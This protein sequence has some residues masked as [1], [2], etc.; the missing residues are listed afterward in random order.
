MIN[1][2]FDAIQAVEIIVPGVSGGN[3]Q[4]LFQFPQLSYLA[5]NSAEIVGIEILTINTITKS[6]ISGT[7]LV[8][9]ANLQTSFLTL[10]G[11]IKG[12]I[13]G[14]EVIQRVALNR[15]NV[16]Q[17]ATPDPFVREVMPLNKMQ[18]DWTK[19]NVYMQTA[20][21]NTGNV[22]FVFNVYFNYVKTIQQY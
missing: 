19:S 9:A 10:Y 11:G 17:N 7:A 3:T 12:V 16:V 13:L 18:V 15:L 20:P 1:F 5:P 22:A 14:S 4:Q 2:E 8:T 6:P 21:G